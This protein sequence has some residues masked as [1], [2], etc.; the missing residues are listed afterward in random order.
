VA[1]ALYGSGGRGSYGG[2]GGACRCC[3]I[4]RTDS[5]VSFSI[6]SRKKKN[7][8]FVLVLVVLLV[9]VLDLVLD[10]VVGEGDAV[11]RVGATVV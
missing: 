3:N 10:L 1:G 11:G 7:R 4:L 2:V 9:V 5:S 8:T 6:V